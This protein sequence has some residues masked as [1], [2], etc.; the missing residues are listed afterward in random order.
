LM[1]TA[2]PFYLGWLKINKEWRLSQLG[3]E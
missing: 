2:D 3:L 1:V